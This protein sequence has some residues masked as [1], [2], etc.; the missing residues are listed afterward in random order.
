MLLSFSTLHVYVV[1]VFYRY[2]VTEERSPTQTQS[3]LIR[4]VLPARFLWEF[5]VSILTE[6]NDRG[7]NTTNQH[8]HGFLG[9]RTRQNSF[10]C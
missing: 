8:S 9:I 7:A 1:C 4:L 2:V 6:W 3:M 10:N 5:H